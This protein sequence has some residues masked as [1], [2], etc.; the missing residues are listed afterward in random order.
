MTSEPAAR[1]GWR[2]TIRVYAQ[3]QVRP[4][5]FLGFSSGLPFLLVFGT[6]SAW[7]TQAHVSRS[8]IG[9][10]S[11]AGL[12]Y[13]LKFFW[14]PI[15][16]RAHLPLLGRLGRRRS[17]MLIAQFGVIAALTGM[18]LTDPA[19][20]LR[21]TALLA[22]CLAFASATQDISVDA[23]RI[24][25]APVE[26]QGAVTAAYQL[27]YRIAM[28]A[29]GAVALHIAQGHGWQITYLSMA[30]LVG[31]GVVTTLLIAEPRAT[32][33]RAAVA[34]EQRV[35]DFVERSG[36]WPDW[37]RSAAAW[38]IGAVV[39]PFTDIFNR[40][41]GGLATL[42]LLF[43]ASYR[44]SDFTMGVMANPFYLDLGFTLDQIAVVSKV[45]GV[46]VTLLGVALCGLLV[47]RFGVLRALF[48]GIVVVCLANC[49][50]SWMAHRD[51]ATVAGLTFA[52][53]FDNIGVGIA[54][55]A[56]IVYLSGLTSPAY[57]ATQYAL[58]GMAWSLPCKFL[59]GFSG[60]IVDAVGYP[61]FFVYTAALSLPAIVLVILLGHATSRLG[62]N[63]AAAQ[64]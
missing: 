36:H 45:Y 6:L 40:L 22:V 47:A 39:C 57:T 31:V 46:I 35:V 16:D 1:R 21:H 41:G 49:Y 18:A 32:I 63:P 60:V 12:S 64:A 4:L 50:F 30:A 53:S 19:E 34:Q 38:I 44:A 27:G 9:Y 11:W 17:W 62:K 58:L 59:A 3:P 20:Q 51:A 55:T 48:V 56:L 37:A 29:A 8:T 43:V 52:I 33:D 26:L 14:S 23:Y 13:S 2:E 7:L 5:L 54:G 24:E 10:F 25:S 15:V 28:I 61:L 42:I